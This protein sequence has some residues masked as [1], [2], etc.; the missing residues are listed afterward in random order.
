MNASIFGIIGYVCFGIA[1][2]FF[3]VS[4]YIFFKL[5]ILNVINELNGKTAKRQIDEIRALNKASRS[6]RHI[7]DMFH[8]END[9]ITERINGTTRTYNPLKKELNE[10]MTEKLKHSKRLQSKVHKNIKSAN[11]SDATEILMEDNEEISSSYSMFTDVLENDLSLAVLNDSTTKLDVY[12]DKFTKE[13]LNFK[14]KKSNLIIH[15]DEYINF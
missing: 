9:Q 4:I 11:N 3:S 6:K 8:V 7:P 13:E 14:I 1:F 12:V 15:T 5:K 10:D 2:I